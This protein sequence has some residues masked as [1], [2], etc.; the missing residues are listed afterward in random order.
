MLLV[1]FSRV[2]VRLI[3]EFLG[4]L[5]YDWYFFDFVIGVVFCFFLII[6][7]VKGLMILRVGILF[8]G[9]C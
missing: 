9:M 1:L 3:G 5:W 7:K 2:G 6:R 4:G 8:L